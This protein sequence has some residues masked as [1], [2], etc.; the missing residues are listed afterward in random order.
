MFIFN[1]KVN[2]NFLSKIFLTLLLLIVISI[3]IFSV[4]KLF[5]NSSFIVNDDINNSEIYSLTTE[6]YTNVLKAVHNNLD[7][8][9]GQQITFSGYIYRVY[10]FDNSQFVLARDMIISSDFQTLVVGFL[11]H[12]NS[13]SSYTDGTW[14]NITRNDYKRKLSW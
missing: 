7:N 13:I 4:Y 10:D 2:S 12:C 9:I 11:C 5:D 3:V 6:N 14:V 1:F 8:Y